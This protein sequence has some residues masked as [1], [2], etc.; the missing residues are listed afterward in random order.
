MKIECE[1]VVGFGRRIEQSRKEA[2]LSRSEV[3]DALGGTAISTLQAW[4]AETRE[5]PISKLM[6]LSQI[7]NVEPCYL[8]TGERGSKNLNIVREQQPAYAARPQTGEGEVVVNKAKLQEAIE[9]LEEVLVITNKE[10]KPAGKA[11]MIWA[12]YEL[13]TEEDIPQ[14]DKMIGFL[15][16]INRHYY[17]G[18]TSNSKIISGQRH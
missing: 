11:Q 4:E 3:C 1:K 9:T 15:K 8:L 7:L 14:K 6:A 17:D 5:P 10:M 18:Q 2:R 12:F 16:L 13:L